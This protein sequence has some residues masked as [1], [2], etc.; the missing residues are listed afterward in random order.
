M[1][2]LHMGKKTLYVENYR[3]KPTC[4]PIFLGERLSKVGEGTVALGEV[5]TLLC[6][7]YLSTLQ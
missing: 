5:D 1:E 3:E 2:R 4:Q 6:L 7:L